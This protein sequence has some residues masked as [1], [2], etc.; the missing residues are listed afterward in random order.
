MK[1]AILPFKSISAFADINT[2]EIFVSQSFIKCDAENNIKHEFAH[3]LSQ[4][5]D[6]GP[7]FYDYLK[8]LGGHHEEERDILKELRK[9]IGI[10]PHIAANIGSI[11]GVQNMLL[12]YHLLASYRKFS[13]AV[14]GTTGHWE[15]INEGTPTISDDSITAK[16][17]LIRLYPTP[18]GTFPVTVLYIPVVTHFRSPHARML[19]Y[20]MMLAEAKI[21]IGNARR[22]ISGMPTPDGGSISY[23]GESLVSE[24]TKERD[25][26]VQKAIL[27][28]EPLG[29]HFM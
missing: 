13:Q 26:I 2:Q 22:K 25:E 21:A 27:L 20:D 8:N 17:Q 23:D 19:A 1:I 18:K 9:Y 7:N 3:I 14:L 16:D 24:G 4:D 12:D 10:P 11:S 28:G 6:H 15:V 29:P 5:P